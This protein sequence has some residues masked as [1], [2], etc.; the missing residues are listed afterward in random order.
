ME[1]SRPVSATMLRLGVKIKKNQCM[2]TQVYN[3]NYSG[4][5]GGRIGNPRP[6]WAARQVQNS[7][8]SLVRT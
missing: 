4:G 1:L 6:A 3:F 5:R 2:V 8:G 7:L